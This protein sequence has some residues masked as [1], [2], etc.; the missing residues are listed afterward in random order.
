[1]SFP[2]GKPILALFVI[3]ILSGSAVLFHHPPAPA[4]LTLWVFSDPH[5]RMYTGTYVTNTP[6][7]GPSLL[8]QFENQTGHSVH[9]DLIAL[10]AL[11]IRLI[12]LFMSG[13]TESGGPDLVEIE[14]GSVGKFFRA[15]TDEVGLL[16]LNGYLEKS[17]WMN[18]IIHARFAPWSKGATIFGVPHDMHPCT[19][20][21]RKD[22]FD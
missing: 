19:I 6:S 10:Q 22:L 20:T 4:D 3:A 14:I 9:L 2:L 1:M 5:A 21:Y 13:A 11:D 12:S 17:G 18:R 15:P 8:Q 7:T 16:P